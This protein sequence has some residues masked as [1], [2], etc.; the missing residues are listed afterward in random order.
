MSTWQS[1]SVRCT[2]TTTEPHPHSSANLELCLPRLFPLKKKVSP[3]KNLQI[4]SVEVLVGI[5][6]DGI[7]PKHPSTTSPTNQI[8]G[9]RRRPTKT[10]AQDIKNKKIRPKWDRAKSDRQSTGISTAQ[11]SM[12]ASSGSRS[13]RCHRCSHGSR[14][15]KRKSSR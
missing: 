15:G 12:L 9:Q 4:M 6:L 14:K 2:R 10:C 3:K 5:A 1:A 7:P 11:N 13:L 8:Y